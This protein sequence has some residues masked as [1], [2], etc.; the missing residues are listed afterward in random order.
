MKPSHGNLI[1]TILPVLILATAAAS[2]WYYYY[3]ELNKNQILTDDSRS[4][5]EQLQA[6]IDKLLEDKTAL[7]ARLASEKKSQ[8]DFNIAQES[9]H[10]E[11]TA[12]SEEKSQLLK[13]LGQGKKSQA[14]QAALLEKSRAEKIAME[15]SLQQQVTRV[16]STTAEL[17][18]E[19]EKRQA[20][21]KSLNAK[22]ST[23]SGEKSELLTQLKLE[24]ESGKQ[25][26]NLKNRLEQELNENRVEISQLKNQLT[27]IKLTSEVLFS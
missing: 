18:A 21:Q 13:Q 9:L 8:E 22:F 23:V 25:I 3:S 7:Q 6:R 11:I 24:Q 17:K 15:T 19:L 20:A 12:I 4:E 10:D 1:I 14:E 27:V 2:G 26:A 16:T 5:R